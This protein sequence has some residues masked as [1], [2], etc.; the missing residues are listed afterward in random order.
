LQMCQHHQVYITMYKCVNI[1]Q[2]FY[3][4]HKLAH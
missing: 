3:K 2:E 1:F 4:G